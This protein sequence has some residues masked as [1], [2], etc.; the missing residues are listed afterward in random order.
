M[1]NTKNVDVDDPKNEDDP[2]SEDHHNNKDSQKI[3]F[4]TLINIFFT[5]YHLKRRSFFFVIEV[6]ELNKGNISAE[7]GK[8]DE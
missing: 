4:K 1:D 5:L 3:G 6:D 2:Q 8:Q 7:A